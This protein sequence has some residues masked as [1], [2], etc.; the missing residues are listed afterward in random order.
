MVKGYKIGIRERTLGLCPKGRINVLGIFFL[1]LLVGDFVGGVAYAQEWGPVIGRSDY[2]YTNSGFLPAGM[3]SSNP[4]DP[5]Y[6]PEAEAADTVKYEREQK[7]LLLG[8]GYILFAMGDKHAREVIKS[9]Q[10]EDY[11]AYMC[12]D[13]WSQNIQGFSIATISNDGVNPFDLPPT[14]DNDDVR[15][16]SMQLNAGQDTP[17]MPGLYPPPWCG[18]GIRIVRTNRGAYTNGQPNG[19]YFPQV[20]VLDLTRVREE[21]DKYYLNVSYRLRD[22][23]LDGGDEG[24]LRVQYMSKPWCKFSNL[25]GDGLYFWRPRSNGH[26][27]RLSGPVSQW[28]NDG[29]VAA[30]ECM[31]TGKEEIDEGTGYYQ[32]NGGITVL[33]FVHMDNAITGGSIESHGKP[34]AK[35]DMDNVF[36]YKPQEDITDLRIVREG[37]GDNMEVCSGTTVL[38]EKREDAKVP[39]KLQFTPKDALPLYLEWFSSNEDVVSVKYGILTFTGKSGTSTI[40]VKA[41]NYDGLAEILTSCVVKNEFSTL[42]MNKTKRRQDNVYP[43]AGAGYH[44]L[45]GSDAVINDWLATRSRQAMNSNRQTNPII[46]DYRWNDPSRNLWI[47]NN[48]WI[49]DPD[50][51]SSHLVEDPALGRP[52]L[53]QGKRTDTREYWYSSNERYTRSTNDHEFDEQGLGYFGQPN[54]WMS[55]TVAPFYCQLEKGGFKLTDKY[56]ASSYVGGWFGM[57]SHFS[58]SEN[59]PYDMTALLEHWDDAYLFVSIRSGLS[60]YLKMEFPWKKLNGEEEI[61]RVILVAPR[62]EMPSLVTRI[63]ENVIHINT[64]NDYLFVLQDEYVHKT[65]TDADSIFVFWKLEEPKYRTVTIDEVLLDW[66]YDYTAC[67][68]LAGVSSAVQSNT[69]KMADANCPPYASSYLSLLPW[70]SCVA[71]T[72]IGTTTEDPESSLRHCHSDH[73]LWLQERSTIPDYVIEGECSVIY[74]TDG[75]LFPY[76]MLPKGEWKGHKFRLKD[77]FGEKPNANDGSLDRFE[78]V[79]KSGEHT[80]WRMSGAMNPRT[81]NPYPIPHKLFSDDL[82]FRWDVRK[83]EKEYIKDYKGVLSGLYGFDPTDEIP[84]ISPYI[85]YRE[86]F[87][88][89][90]PHGFYSNGPGDRLGLDAMFFYYEIPGNL[91]LSRNG[92]PVTVEK[93]IPQALKLTYDPADCYMHSIRWESDHPLIQV[94][95]D[96]VVTGL[97]SGITGTVTVTGVSTNRVTKT[98][99]CDVHVVERQKEEYSDVVRSIL[100]PEY[101]G[102]LDYYLMSIDESVASRLNAGGRVAYDLRP[103]TDGGKNTLDVWDNTYRAVVTPDEELNSFDHPGQKWISFK[104]NNPFWTGAAFRM[105][106]TQPLDV[107]KIKENVGDYYLHVAARVPPGKTGDITKFTF[108][109]KTA[110]GKDS[111]YKIAITPIKYEKEG[112]VVEY[113]GYRVLRGYSPDG[114]WYEMSIPLKQTGMPVPFAGASTAGGEAGGYNFLTFSTGPSRSFE[115]TKEKYY[116]VD[117]A[118]EVHLDAV[119]LYRMPIPDS[120]CVKGKALTLPVGTQTA[121]VVCYPVG[122]PNYPMR[123]KVKDGS[124]SHIRVDNLGRIYGVAPTAQPV[125]IEYTSWWPTHSLNDGNFHLVSASDYSIDTVTG[126]AAVTVV[127]ATQVKP[128]TGRSFYPLL[129]DAD[130]GHEATTAGMFANKYIAD[131]LRPNDESRLLDLWRGALSPDTTAAGETLPGYYGKYSRGVLLKKDSGDWAGIALRVDLEKDTQKDLRRI[132]YARN[133]YYFHIALRAKEDEEPSLVTL[134]FTDGTDTIRIPL[135]RDGNNGMPT[136]YDFPRDGEWYGLCI[137][138]SDDLFDVTDPSGKVTTLFEKK[139][140]TTGELNILSITVEGIDSAAIAVDAAFF[141]HNGLPT[142]EGLSLTPPVDGIRVGE[143]G[144]IKVRSI[145]DFLGEVLP[146]DL[147]WTSDKEWLTGENSY[148]CAEQSGK[149]T[150]TARYLGSSP[151]VKSTVEITVHPSLFPFQ[152]ADKGF[153]YALLLMDPQTASSLGGGRMVDDL[154]PNDVHRI[155]EI[156]DESFTP[157]D[158]ETEERNSF[159]KNLSW[160]SL[161]MPDTRNWAGGAIVNTTLERHRFPFGIEP[162]RSISCFHIALKSEQPLSSYTFRLHDGVNQ[163]APF[164]IGNCPNPDGVEPYRTFPH[165]GKWHSVRIPLTDTLFNKLFKNGQNVLEADSGTPYF[166]FTTFADFD[167]GQTLDFDAALFY[168]VGGAPPTSITLN[169]GELTL[170]VGYTSLLE[171]ANIVPTEAYC[172][173]GDMIWETSDPAVA[174]VQSGIVTA[175]KEGTVTISVHLPGYPA[176]KNSCT[177]TVKPSSFVKAAGA[178]SLEGT[179]YRIFMAGAKTMETLRA[180]VH[181]RLDDFWGPDVRGTAGLSSLQI[182]A[183]TMET[184]DIPAG[185]K[186]SYGMEDSY[187]GLALTDK[188]WGGGAFSTGK[189]IPIDLREMVAHK[190]DYVF[191]I[192]LKTTEP[193]VSYKFSLTDGVHTCHFAIGNTWY[194]E[195]F[196]IRD[197]PHDGTWHELEIPLSELLLLPGG[198]NLYSEVMNSEMGFDLLSFLRL[199]EPGNKMEMDAIFFYCPRK[200]PTAVTFAFA[201]TLLL[202]LEAIQVIPSF[203]PYAGYVPDNKWTWT[204][205][206]ET[207]V[208]QQPVVAVRGSVLTAYQEGEAQVEFSVPDISQKVKFNVTVGE[209]PF[210]HSLLGSRYH[211]VFMDRYNFTTIEKRTVSDLRTGVPGVAGTPEIQIWL[212]DN[213]SLTLKDGIEKPVNSYGAGGPN[214]IAFL[215]FRVSEESNWGGGAFRLPGSGAKIDLTEL[216]EKPEEYVFHVAMRRKTVDAGYRF[217]LSN[218]R[219]ERGFIIGNRIWMDNTS[220]IAKNEIPIR[221]FPSDGKWYELEIPLTHPIFKDFFNSP[222]IV[223]EGGLNIVSFVTTRNPGDIAPTDLCVDAVFFYRRYRP[224]TNIT[225]PNEIVV[226]E[227]EV[228]QA[229]AISE[230]IHGLLRWKTLNN[231]TATATNEGFVSG[232][233]QGSTKLVVSYGD[234]QV[235]DPSMNDDEYVLVWSDEFDGANDALPDKWRWGYDIGTGEGGWGNGE[236]Q[237]YTAN[238]ENARMRDGHLVI[239]AKKENFF[240]SEYTSARLRSKQGWKYGKVEVSFKLSSGF[241]TWPA[242]WM[243]PVNNVYGAWPAS[244]EIDIMEHVGRLPTSIMGTVHMAGASGET[245]PSGTY[246]VLPD[247]EMEPHKVTLI[248]NEDSIKWYIDDRAIPFFSFDKTANV[249]YTQWPFDENFYLILNQAVGGYLGG[250][251]SADIWP[252]EFLVDYVRV[253]Q[254]PQATP[255]QPFISD[256]C[257]ITVLPRATIP[258]LE[259]VDYTVLSFGNAMMDT[260]PSSVIK[261]DLRGELALQLWESSFSKRELVENDTDSYGK[262]D[263]GNIGLQVGSRGW[264]GGA[265]FLPVGTA[266]VDLTALSTAARRGLFFF[267]MALRSK[268]ERSAYTFTFSDGIKS[269][270]IVIGNKE[271]EGGIAPKYDF[272]RDGAWHEINIPLSLPEF[273]DMFENPIHVEGTGLNFLTF[274]AGGEPWTTLDMDALFFYDV[275][276]QQLSLSVDR[277]EVNMKVQGSV[278][279]NA[280]TTPAIKVHQVKWQSLNPE[281]ATV[282]SEGFVTGLKAGDATIV[283]SLEGLEKRCVVHVTKEEIVNSRYGS[284]YHTFFVDE[285]TF[286]YFGERLERDLRPGTNVCDLDN[287]KGQLDF[288]PSLEQGTNSYG[289]EKDWL[290]MA[291][292]RGETWSGGAFRIKPLGNGIDM[293]HVALARNEYSLH[294]ALR[295]TKP[296]SSY[297][298]QLANGHGDTARFVIG[299]QWGE[300]GLLPIYDFARDGQWHEIDIHLDS[301]LFDGFFDDVIAASTSVDF[302]AFILSGAGNELGMDAIFFYK[303]PIPVEGF[304]M[305]KDTVWVYEGEAFKLQTDFL[306]VDAFSGEPITW[307]SLNTDLLTIEEDNW[308]LAKVAS[309]VYVGVE[310]KFGNFKDTCYVGIQSIPEIIGSL[311]GSHYYVLSMG[312]AVFANLADRM[313]IKDWRPGKSEGCRLNVVGASFNATG[314]VGADSYGYLNTNWVSLAVTDKGWS[315]ASFVVS[316]PQGIDLRPIVKEEVRDKYFFHIALKCEHNLPYTFTF[317]NGASSA[318]III[319]D[320]ETYDFPRDGRWHELD[321]PLSDQVFNGLYTGPFGTVG[322]SIDVLAFSAG[323]IQGTTLDI[324]AVFFY[325]TMEEPAAVAVTPTS[326]RVEEQTVT[327]VTTKLLPEGAYGKVTWLSKNESVATVHDGIV[328]AIGIGTTSIEVQAGNALTQI[329]IEVLPKRQT[330]GLNGSRY[331][332]ISMDETTLSGLTGR[333]VVQEDMRPNI[334]DGYAMDIWEGS[335]NVLSET[336]ETNSYGRLSPW[337]RLE[338]GNKGWSGAAFTIGNMVN[339]M[340]IAVTRVIHNFHVALKS[341][342]DVS[343]YTFTF[344]DG[345]EDTARIVI[346]NKPND[347]GILPKYDFKRNGVWQEIDIPLNLPEFNGLYDQPF[348]EYGKKLSFVA[349]SAGKEKGTVLDMDALFF[350]RELMAPEDIEVSP[351]LLEMREQE[352][353]KLSVKMLP[354]GSY[355]TVVWRSRNEEI[356]TVRNGFVS[357]LKEGTTVLEAQVGTIVRTVSVKVSPKEE[358]Y[359]LFGTRYYLLS[360]DSITAKR[361]KDMGNIVQD[362]R[363]GVNNNRLELWSG[364]LSELYTSGPNSFNQYERWVGLEVSNKGWS[365]GAFVV[366]DGVD[367][368]EI[369]TERE[370]WFFHIALKSTQPASAYTFTFVDTDEDGGNKAHIV[371]GNGEGLSGQQ[372]KYDFARDGKWHEVDIPLSLPEFDLLYKVAFTGPNK[373][374]NL[375]EFSAGGV[376]GTALEIDAM[377]FYKRIPPTQLVPESL[378]LKEQEV[379]KLSVLLLPEGAYAPLQ[380]KSLDESI[381]TVRDGWVSGLRAGTAKVWISAGQTDTTVDVTVLPKEKINALKGL[382]YYP[383]LLGNSTFDKLNERGAV[384]QDF[385]PDPPEV[386]QREKELQIWENT[387]IGLSATDTNSLGQHEEWIRLSVTDKGWS[388]GAFA[389]LKSVDWRR[390]IEERNNHF[391]HIALK[392]TRQTTYTFTFSDGSHAAQIVVG[393][394]VNAS[395]VGPKYNFIRNGQWQELNIPLSLPEFDGM[396]EFLFGSEVSPANLMAFSAGGV[397]GDE[398]HMDAVFLY[399]QEVLAESIQIQSSLTMQAGETVYLSTVMKPETAKREPVWRSLNPLVATARQ[400][401]IWAIAPGKAE[402]EVSV[403]GVSDTCQVTVEPG[404]SRNSLLGSHYHLLFMG[405]KA[406]DTLLLKERSI[407]ADF[408]PGVKSLNK[409]NI[410]EET[411][412]TGAATGPNSYGHEDPWIGWSVNNK[413]WSGGA[414]VVQGNV[415]LRSIHAERQ[416]YYFHVA[417]RSQTDHLYTFTFTDSEDTIQVIIGDRPTEDGSLPS[418]NFVRDG[419]WHELNIPLNNPKFSGLFDKELDRTT[420]N[421]VA[422]SA[423]SVQGTPLNMDAVFFYKNSTRLSGLQVNKKSVT[424]LEQ[425]VIKLTVTPSPEETYVIYEWKSLNTDVVTVREGVVSAVGQGKAEVVV[426]CKGLSDTQ[427]LTDT[428]R[429]TVMPK[430]RPNNLSGSSYYVM[431]LGTDVFSFLLQQERIRVKDWRPNTGEGND[432]HIWEGTFNAQPESGTDSYGNLGQ[433]IRMTVTDKGWSGGAFVT[434]EVIDLRELYR[435]RER[436]HFHVALKSTQPKT[437]YTFTFSDDK[438]TVQ[439]AIGDS[440][441]AGIF[442]R[443]NFKRDGLWHEIEIPLSLP[444]FDHLFDQLYGG[445]ISNLVAFSAGGEKGAVLEMDAV[446]YYKEVP[447]PT[448]YLLPD[449]TIK[450]Q[451]VVL[452]KGTFVPEDAF[453]TLQWR[454][455]DTHIA[456]VNDGFVSGMN[457][458]KTTIEAIYK[459]KVIGSCQVTIEAATKANSLLG[460]HYYLLLSGEYA[461][462]SLLGTNRIVEKDW[463]PGISPANNL[464]IWEQTFTAG[465]AAGW[466]SYGVEEPWLQW[467]VTDKGWSGGA[468]TIVGEVDLRDVRTLRDKYFFHVALKS[469]KPEQVYTFTFIDGKDTARIVVGDRLGDNLTPPRY[470]FKRDGQWHELNIPLS[471]P[472]FANLY[473]ETFGSVQKVASIVAFSAGGIEGDIL[474]MDAVFFYRGEE[475]AKGISLPTV[476]VVEE[477]A[478]T[479]VP[480]TYDPPSA[481]GKISWVSQDASIATVNDNLVSG[482]KGGE[483]VITATCNKMQAS[484]TVKVL[485]KAK[486][487]SLQGSH[488]YVL[489]MGENTFNSLLATERIIMADWRPGAI[490]G[491]ELQVWEATFKASEQT[492][493]NSYGKEEP[494]IGLEV[495]G[496]EWSGGAFAVTGEMNLQA[497]SKARD[498]YYFHVALKST[499]KV[500]SYTFT[501]TDGTDTAEIVVGNCPGEKN[502]LP[503]YDFVRDGQW[504]EI[505]I[506]M[507]LPEFDGMYAAPFGSTSKQV[508]I[509]AFSAG[510]VER[511]TLD[512]DAAFFYKRQLPLEQ[513]KL[514]TKKMTIEEQDVVLL[515]VEVEPEGVFVELDWKSLDPASVGVNEGFV[516]GFKAKGEAIPIVVYGSGR[517]DTCYIKVNTSKWEQSLY[518]SNYHVLSLGENSFKS[519][520]NRVVTD[521]RA[522]SDLQIWTSTFNASSTSNE[523]NSYGIADPWIG[524]TVSDKG[525]SGGAFAITG[526]IDLT[527]VRSDRGKYCFHISLKS[528]QPVSVYTFSFTDGG[529]DTVQI[530]V[531]N[532]KNVN[533]LMPKYN[534]TRDGLWHEIQIPLSLPEF[535]NLYK[536]PFGGTQGSVNLVTFSAGGDVG[537]TLNMDAAFFYKAGEKAIGIELPQTVTIKEQEVVR[538]LPEGVY[539]EVVWSSSNVTIAAVNKGFITGVSA[540]QATITA[541]RG[542]QEVTCSVTVEATPDTKSLQGDYYYLLS[543]DASSY[544]TLLGTNRTIVK[545]WR[546]GLAKGGELQV[547]DNTF[548]VATLLGGANSFGLK[549]SWVTLAVADKGW[550]GASFKVASDIDLKAIVAE[551]EKYYFHIALKS[552]QQTVYTLGFTDGIHTTSFVIGNDLNGE[553]IDPSYNFVRDGKWHEIEIPLTHPKFAGF[554]E[555]NFNGEQVNLLTFSAGGVEGSTLDID[556]VFFYAKAEEVTSVIL[557]KETLQVEEQ[558]VVRLTTNVPIGASGRIVWRS[559]NKDV[560]TVA[561][562]FVS[563]LRAGTARI[564][565]QVGSLSDTCLVT[566]VPCPSAGGLSGVGFFVF[567]LGESLVKEIANGIVYD[568]RPKGVNLPTSLM[569]WE[570]TFTASP[571]VGA[572]SYGVQEPWVS[573]MV[574]DKGWSGGAFHVSPEFGMIDMQRIRTKRSDYAFHVTLKSTQSDAVFTFTFSDGSE[575]AVI[576][577]GPKANM[578]GVAPKYNFI[579]DGHWKEFNIPLSEPEF[580]AIFNKPFGGVESLTGVSLLA[581]SAGGEKGTILDMDA[582]FLYERVEMVGMYFTTPTLNLPQQTVRKLDLKLLPEGVASWVS[583]QSSDPAVATVN[584]G[585]VSAFNVG[586]TTIT[587]SYGNYSASCLVTVTATEAINSLLGSNYFVVQLGEKALAQI[588]DKVVYDFRPNGTNN[589]LQ[590]WSATFA[591]QAGTTVDSYGNSDNWVRMVVL[592]QGWSG[593]AYVTSLAGNELNLCRLYDERDKYFFHVALKSTQAESAYTFTFSDGADVAKIVIGN[594]PDGDDISPRYDFVRDGKW[595]EINIPLSLPEFNALYESVITTSTVNVIAFSAGG[596]QGTVLDMDALFFYKRPVT[597]TDIVLSDQIL[598]LP[599]Q[600][601]RRLTVGTVP[602]DAATSSVLWTSSNPSIA[603]VND[604]FVTGI[605]EGKVQITATCNGITKTC[606]VTVTGLGTVN[607]LHGSNYVVLM[608]GTGAFEAISSALNVVDLRPG[609]DDNELYIWEGTFDAGNGSGANSYGHLDE[610]L[611]MKVTGKGWSGSSFNVPSNRYMPDWTSMQ[612]RQEYS[613]H[614]ALKSS[615]ATSAYTF[616]FTDCADTIRL[617]IGNRAGENG[618]LPLF[619]F[620]RDGQWHEIDVPLNHPIFDPLFDSRTGS[621]SGGRTDVMAFSAGGKEGD[622]LNM[623]AVFF[624]RHPAY[625]TGIGLDKTTVELPLGQTLTLKPVLTPPHAFAGDITWGSEQEEFVTVDNKGVVKGIKEGTATIV[626]HTGQYSATCVV[627]VYKPSIIRLNKTDLLLSPG[628]EEVL[629]VDRSAFK[630]TGGNTWRSDNPVIATVSTT[631]MVKAVKEGV[632]L[633]EVSCGDV[634]DT[635]MVTVITEPPAPTT[636]PSLQGDDYYVISLAEAPFEVI[637]SKVAKDFRPNNITSQLQVWGNSFEVGHSTGI[638][639]YG[640]RESWTSLAVPEVSIGWSGG[641]YNLKE[642]FGQVDMTPIAET[643]SDFVFH[644]ALRS[645]KTSTFYLFTFSDSRQEAR[646]LIG[647]ESIEGRSPDYDFPRDGL[648]HE[649]EVPLSLLNQQGVTYDQPFTGDVNILTFVSTGIPRT[650]IDMDAI[651]FY[652][653]GSTALSGPSGAGL[654]LYPLPAQDVLHIGGLEESVLVRLLDMTGRIR[655]LQKTDDILN[656]SSLPSGIYILCV[657]QQVFR[658]YKE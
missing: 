422:F 576:V 231:T 392:S 628:M 152:P 469:T 386:L 230:D 477:G 619:D 495:T 524:L 237:Y 497:I 511:T 280:V 427:W 348:G 540:G 568:F 292:K 537:T 475:A 225:L 310:A 131:D 651:F 252:R 294:M 566:V 336:G 627:T 424:L 440:A 145:P 521:W 245:G 393:N 37:G 209:S 337:I 18:T 359:P 502:I 248:W 80:L 618:V 595:H 242:V 74:P 357:A 638:N 377:F 72:A 23:D 648:W 299:N 82:L 624:Y 137:P 313:V 419:K 323:G 400:G 7:S 527:Q 102:G 186:N 38:F 558:Q 170:E 208:G 554:Y 191:H 548:E 500:S 261:R 14:T 255:S 449:V 63:S 479:Y 212:D 52:T 81:Y 163:T 157:R 507:G 552:T 71:E 473:D 78:Q 239:T 202:P 445:T 167:K 315:D 55:L 303:R 529:K 268:D 450:E 254:K 177:V 485:A 461:F 70:I 291:T 200:I 47:Y 219:E 346:G 16:I 227:G 612:N 39:L 610:W 532:R 362:M 101:H 466:N 232:L 625:T 98:A 438:D 161:Q 1:C 271:G 76:E 470:N 499:Q 297:T 580:D 389:V 645:R 620:A 534:F 369:R 350:Y 182:W 655:L 428:C 285:T 197:F 272:A 451:D 646:L 340:P 41:R 304:R 108:S 536:E 557:S 3:G 301:P 523:V 515:D 307:R 459:G 347:D 125:Q 64:N 320:G 216:A 21:R 143:T 501:F 575:E 192:A 251:P 368:Q 93:G 380:W 658:F 86:S 496:K 641:A 306:P 363:P 40:T 577:V 517:T 319:G 602:T 510:G 600:S 360:L 97:K 509:L 269:A 423:G 198:E 650:A 587:A 344:T 418:Y 406:I 279:L 626:A 453:D 654:F 617:V 512:I 179:H 228:I 621:I 156:W 637:R 262:T 95:S 296:F 287:W 345:S 609:K 109:W 17:Q 472:E 607:S 278:K 421:I 391:F 277:Q 513:L 530:A 447:A 257:T 437:V 210:R 632:T 91:T 224:I 241:G 50:R 343:A 420:N 571:T 65:Q 331:Y 549:E 452:M 172:P 51:D 547:W 188:G 90:A 555:S 563:A 85:N 597:L 508:A 414:F 203:K 586:T 113:E 4:E 613:F 328:S 364:T 538:L 528:M 196:P 494:W 22:F 111:S 454:S 395:G 560:A 468:F 266:D 644:I 355:A 569:V 302:F 458:G 522:N 133:K 150:I 446:F 588:K 264:S 295:S 42:G 62:V 61:K 99:S 136:K 134:R 214:E 155:I 190:E 199:G 476:I 204:V 562:G 525:W 94:S 457:V 13:W 378:T 635:C 283:A 456:T 652:R 464:M 218:G 151:V 339:L 135:G 35:A 376:A 25:T 138:L 146:E 54:D 657:Y 222:I 592:D 354:V 215:N 11:T 384:I 175:L 247:A 642:A 116:V 96:G 441:E 316:D 211:V 436:V 498:D 142:L 100:G 128:S 59:Q 184:A 49:Y 119:Y 243:L 147:E 118:A 564:I 390:V 53:I 106:A 516:T 308:L 77:I 373:P 633:I 132:P 505:N 48:D 381:F 474:D 550:S 371:I 329:P 622:L 309:S 34:G 58:A 603:T 358:I 107:S 229:E 104:R 543:L 286:A 60:G 28:L 120:V 565:A 148:L 92:E 429:I 45:I 338:V 321:I 486:Q 162:Y 553:G 32:D 404:E 68:C 311:T 160:L 130:F 583:W 412:I 201:D 234:E 484:C 467:I 79:W 312:D 235:E 606:E 332:V 126:F 647:N 154:R 349:F 298:F 89:D 30:N 334:A 284:H 551:R 139:L 187:V 244:G 223:P 207:N 539:G 217:I 274:L 435:E 267:H 591:G 260:L 599:K 531:G 581:F 629:T 324:D 519:I 598:S 489:S 183:S 573:L 383:L 194:E 491:N 492:G 327:V 604:A 649:I 322:Q 504:H 178:T 15:W 193:I 122:T 608:M 367:L 318:Q 398:L 66:K 483:T 387:F 653:K 559:L 305:R 9:R 366:E 317:S 129:F 289:L 375:V 397:T 326:I 140:P 105:G 43:L 409:L 265:F 572:N 382:S 189:G 249:N 493:A 221:N 10:V 611:Q 356:A 361:L 253:Y 480:V 181:Y 153:N 594:C 561:N 596:T 487:N 159:E 87:I 352:V 56:P 141:F 112:E 639:S 236:L 288:L 123:L 127:S 372:P 246:N 415:D 33:G 31:Y 275:A 431:L 149:G 430:I 2:P 388:G 656:V 433:W 455:T 273:D 426:Y 115:N 5:D 110:D 213:E 205:T 567:S 616:T 434:G 542:S 402:I 341:R 463:R 57:E 514:S 26:W 240:D 121:G 20:N 518:G 582:V 44:W 593:S 238:K 432:L 166:T 67:L 546:L 385:R 158:K 69:S 8:S 226:P 259:G 256:T 396:Y 103:G 27:Q 351:S 448:A 6:T 570:S 503:K 374:L 481:Y 444:E 176:I 640:T 506:P 399:K 353:K 425:D 84:K 370:N 117:T 46:K 314:R 630:G 545:N 556:A 300:G 465:T 535:D 401:V 169:H 276:E 413:G 590:V 417:L 124:K 195:L 462:N 281:V 220:P 165:D 634:A 282:A 333:G 574:G 144:K 623:D 335:F 290:R 584:R 614:I 263:G 19:R 394:E 164:V 258:S 405:A 408:R 293:K 439:I 579:R 174:V 488:Y 410:W 533:G 114:E 365:G 482:F 407:L 270:S 403:D 636:Y 643:P 180:S 325:K 541:K 443:Y 206:S 411:F 250:T 83:E 379:K 478:V 416:D 29:S 12:H 233:K 526:H 605:N 88:L 615:Q 73:R 471:L 544:G 168:T 631:G 342:Q 36:Y 75:E 185:T 442:P 460:S 589:E 171:I 585:M 490:S 330:A 520:Q 578:D 601:V 173:P 24:Y